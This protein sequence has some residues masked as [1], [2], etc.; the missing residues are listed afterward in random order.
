[1][2]LQIFVVSPETLSTLRFLGAIPL[3]AAI[4]ALFLF[5]TSNK[6]GMILL[7]AW[8]IYLVYQVGVFLLV[9]STP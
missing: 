1:L 6:K 3:A 2:G 5:K 9:T 8:G 4:L 7:L